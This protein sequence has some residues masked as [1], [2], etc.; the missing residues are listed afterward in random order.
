[1]A[2]AVNSVNALPSQMSNDYY[3][4]EELEDLVIVWAKML[5]T[6][7]DF[8]QTGDITNMPS[9]DKRLWA[10]YLLGKARA[11]AAAN[12]A[13]NDTTPS[14]EPTPDEALVTVDKQMTGID[15]RQALLTLRT[16]FPGSGNFSGLGVPLT[17]QEDISFGQRILLMNQDIQRIEAQA[18]AK[19]QKHFVSKHIAGA[20]SNAVAML[21]SRQED[22]LTMSV[23][24]SNLNRLTELQAEH[25]EASRY[26]LSSESTM[27]RTL[28]GIELTAGELQGLTEGMDDGSVGSLEP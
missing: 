1:M 21:K 17:S 6:F 12:A 2:A 11:E 28:P 7:F 8:L 24:A 23:Y 20:G 3:N 16:M 26:L 13:A 15:W 9:E 18:T 14:E 25:D 4:D 5:V 10:S 22:D 19:H 27:R